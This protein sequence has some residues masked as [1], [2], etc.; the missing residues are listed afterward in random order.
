MGLRLQISR[1]PVA[2]LAL[3]LA[4]GVALV[5][6]APASAAKADEAAPSESLAAAI[7]REI[8]TTRAA[9]GLRRLT[10]ATPLA[11]SAR[12]HATSMAA[13]GYFS[14]TSPDGSSSARRITSFYPASEGWNAAVGEIL[15]WATGNLT[16]ERAVSM[17]LASAPHHDE[18]L[19]RRWRN[20]GVSAVRVASAPGVY[21]GRDVTIVVV[22]FGR[23]R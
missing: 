8:N 19:S 10:V 13:L 20:V 14:H 3:L 23:R 2:I 1:R 5:L 9:H 18:L 12:Q 17:W 7:V 15:A 21:G 16:A 6:G 22:D 4:I 11:R